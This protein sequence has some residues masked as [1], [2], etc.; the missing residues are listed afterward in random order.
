MP[1]SILGPGNSALDYALLLLLYG[2]L[3]V[4]MRPITRRVEP[5]F[6]HTYRVLF[7][8]WSVGTF[9]ANY[10]LY[11]AGVMSFLP[12]LNNFLHTFV[13]IGLC[14]SFLYAGVYRNSMAEQ[15]IVFAVFSFIVKWAE[16]E[17]LGTWEHGH[18]FGIDGNLAYIVGW[19]LMDGLYPVISL[20]GLRWLSRFI[21]GIVT[22][23]VAVHR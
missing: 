18:F 7:W 4:V 8:S 11:R 12:W 14:L 19:S 20:V 21:P 2:G 10:L 15:F 3:F 5:D 16:Q 22:P 17:L 9:T 23:T 6:R 13:W 1:Q